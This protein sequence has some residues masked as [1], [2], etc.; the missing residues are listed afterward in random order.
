MHS[1][2][3]CSLGSPEQTA[4]N[5]FVA[6]LCVYHYAEFIVT[7]YFHPEAVSWNSNANTGFLI[8]HSKEYTFAVLIAFVE[9]LVKA[10]LGI[11][12]SFIALAGLACGGVLVLIGHFFRIGSE[13]T[14][15]ANF[16]HVISS[17]QQ[18]NHVL[19]TWG[20]YRLCR[21]PGYFG[22]AIWSIGTQLMLCNPVSLC[23]YI[24]ASKMFF[25]SRL[26]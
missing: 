15:G 14:A 22:W 13:V 18:A 16:T 17:D 9:A 19:V 26:E 8:N 6:S 2:S 25:S 7:A 24:K 23:L 3:V 4:I 20:V 5:L 12:P 10:Y 1:L 21:H 11:V